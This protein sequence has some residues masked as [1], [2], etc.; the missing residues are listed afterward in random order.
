MR[1]A[2]VADAELL[3]AHRRLMLLDNGS[4]DGE[5][6]EAMLSRFREWIRPRLESANYRAWIVED[7]GEP[8]ASASLWMKE[9]Q[10]RLGMEVDAAPY[11]LNV[12]T[13]PDYRQQGLAR[14]MMEAILETC[15]LEGMPTVD[16]HTS[17]SGRHLYESLGFE[18]TNEMR[19]NLQ[20]AFR[21]KA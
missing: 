9:V 20:E 21:P 4:E 3:G 19:L 7:D 6:M 17:E 8:I 13:A 14:R 2:S 5:T 12:Y 11:V 15:R 10:P 16:L 18:P 1:V